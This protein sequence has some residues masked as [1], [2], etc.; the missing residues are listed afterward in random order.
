MVPPVFF[1]DIDKPVTDFLSENFHGDKVKFNLKSTA[2]NGTRM[3]L[4]NV[5][6]PSGAITSELIFGRLFKHADSELTCDVTTKMDLTG[7]VTMTHVLNNLADGLQL[8]FTGNVNA[9]MSKLADQS[10]AFA[11]KYRMDNLSLLAKLERQ[12]LGKTTAT[13]TLMTSYQNFGFGGEAVFSNTPGESGK[14]ATNKATYALGTSYKCS[15]CLFTIKSTENF[16]KMSVGYWQRVTSNLTAGAELRHT[17]NAEKDALALSVCTL[18]KLDNTS[19]LKS[20]LSSNGILGFAYTSKMC[21]HLN[22]GVSS[23]FNVVDMSKGINIG[24]SF[25]FQ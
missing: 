6:A 12:R 24:A 20:K 3:E 1:A 4:K 25:N 19:T 13:T 10:A 5:R 23:D 14:P 16:T 11:L 21:D 2:E 22:L 8:E 7:K 15:D 18:H 9:N 17:L